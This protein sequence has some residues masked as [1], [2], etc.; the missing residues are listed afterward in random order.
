MVFKLHHLAFAI[1]QLTT[2]A[3]SAWHHYCKEL[4]LKSCILP[5]D[6]VTHWNSTY[7]MLSF[8]VKYCSVIDAMMADKSLKLQNYKLETEEWVIAEDLMTILLVCICII[9][10]INPHANFFHSNTKI[11][12]SFSCKTL[13]VLL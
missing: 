7:Y 6:V 10:V 4:K 2:I 8:A 11:Q 3:L 1:V 13:P 9:E 5:C 12:C